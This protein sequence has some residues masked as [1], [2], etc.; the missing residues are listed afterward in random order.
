M[1]RPAA[2]RERRHAGLSGLGW[3]EQARE[4]SGNQIAIGLGIHRQR[5]SSY[6]R[7]ERELPILLAGELRHRYG[8][9][10]RLALFRRGAR[11]LRRLQTATGRSATSRR[12]PGGAPSPLPAHCALTFRLKV[13]ISPLLGIR[14]GPL[15]LGGPAHVARRS[16]LTGAIMLMVAFPSA[17]K[18]CW[19][20]WGYSGDDYLGQNGKQ[21]RAVRGMTGRMLP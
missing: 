18:G 20:W 10:L 7:G 13:G 8:C 11:E 3:L 12:A 19:D 15:A 9:T 17:P 16:A 21:M 4:L 5:W 2:P 14:S 6:R 1:G